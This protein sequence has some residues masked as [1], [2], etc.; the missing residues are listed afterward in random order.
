MNAPDHTT[1]GPGPHAPAE[2]IA[3]EPRARRH[4]GGGTVLLTR[5]ELAKAL[6]YSERT[7]D[8]IT[9]SRTIP[10]IRMTTRG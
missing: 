9:R 8:R 7:I 10:S 6:G 2:P 4:T 1:D 5:R 3:T